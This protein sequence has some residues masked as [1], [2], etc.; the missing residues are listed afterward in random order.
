MQYSYSFQTCNSWKSGLK[1]KKKKS[2]LELLI[3]EV[4][5]I[6]KP[7]EET[8]TKVG[9]IITGQREKPGMTF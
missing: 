9:K 7:P 3:R 8:A 2:K 5:T 6:D 1:V 4:E